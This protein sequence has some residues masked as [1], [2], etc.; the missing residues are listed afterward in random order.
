MVYNVQALCH[1]HCISGCLLSCN[2]YVCPDSLGPGAGVVPALDPL[3]RSLADL[4]TSIS[5][6]QLYALLLGNNKIAGVL[7]GKSWKSLIQV[8]MHRVLLQH[9]Q[10]ISVA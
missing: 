9:M 1:M 2:A 7:P 10:L 5:L 4:V 8:S 3:Q 6:L